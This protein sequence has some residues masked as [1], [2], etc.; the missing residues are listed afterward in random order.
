[1]IVHPECD[2]A[3]VRAADLH[4]STEQIIGAV[5]ESPAGAAW[6]IGTEINLVNRLARLHADKTIVSLAEGVTTKC[7]MMARID[8]PH[9]CWALENVAAGNVVN[10]VTVLPNIRHDAFLAIQRMVSLKA[11][12]KAAGMK[13]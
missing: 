9:L 12:A 6:A 10:R 11:V 7:T 5:A 2:I 3:V 13:A 8:L 4:G 1:M